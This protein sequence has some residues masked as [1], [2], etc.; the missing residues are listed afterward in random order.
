[1]Y[2]SWRSGRSYEPSTFE[3]GHGSREAGSAVLAGI[4]TVCAELLEKYG[5]RTDTQAFAEFDGE[6]AVRLHKACPIPAFLIG[7]DSLW[8][9]I[10]CVEMWELVV[11]R[12]GSEDESG[13]SVGKD[14]FG[15]GGR[16]ESLPKRLWM[17]AEVAFDPSLDEPYELAVRGGMDFWT[18]GVIRRLYAGSRPFTRALVR[19]QFPEAGEFRGREYRPQ[20]LSLGAVRELYKR[21]RHFQ[22]FTALATLDETGAKELIE[23]IAADL[24]A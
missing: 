8:R 1:M 20:T 19:F 9:Y 15:L 24:R 2:E 7:S 3:V 6:C 10:A 14:N 12:H 23:S 5:S 21:L 22:A 18:S 11:W 13:V 4:K 17:R 16:W